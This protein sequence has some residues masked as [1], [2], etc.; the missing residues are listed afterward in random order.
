VKK[1]LGKDHE[2]RK[3]FTPEQYT[4]YLKRKAKNSDALIP[5][6]KVPSNKK[7][8]AKNKTQ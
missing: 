3:D 8:E 7:F 6:N 4:A 1:N 2:F 5:E